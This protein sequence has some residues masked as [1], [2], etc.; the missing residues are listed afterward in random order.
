M[1]GR[2]RELDRLG[3]NGAVT[4]QEQAFT[5]T[6]PSDTGRARTPIRFVR[7]SRL[8]DREKRPTAFDWPQRHS[9]RRPRTR[10]PYVCEVRPCHFPQPHGYCSQDSACRV[11]RRDVPDVSDQPPREPR[12][13]T[14]ARFERALSCSRRAGSRGRRPSPSP[15]LEGVGRYPRATHLPAHQCED[16]YRERTSLAGRA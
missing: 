8:E 5:P 14:D 13:R 6:I 7:D 2:A 15:S 16:T 9:I 12:R 10:H 3:N 11:L 4:R 1:R